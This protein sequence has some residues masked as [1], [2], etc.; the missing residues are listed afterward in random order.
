[1][2][3]P[4]NLGLNPSAQQNMAHL[5]EE[6]EN[7]RLSCYSRLGRLDE[8]ALQASQQTIGVPRWPSGR[9]HFRVVHRPGG[10]VMLI[11]DG[12]S[13]PFDDLQPEAN[14]NGL[15]L[16]FFLETPALEIASS[17]SEIKAS[18]QFQLL[19]TVCSLAAGHGGIRHII[20]DMSLLSTEAEG[21][22]QVIPADVAA[23][24]A[25]KDGRVGALLG[26]TDANPSSEAYVPEVI[27]GMPLSEVRLVN[28]KLLTLPE[29]GL[30]TELGSEGRRKLSELFVGRDRLA[31]SLK[32]SSMI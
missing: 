4:L 11:S 26:L 29:L 24:I 13:D 5:L 28:I 16:E 2:L 12:L 1:V 23:A 19:Y 14:Q 31:S 17:P 3:L 7:A 25:N 8:M 32:R 22:A 9:Q 30:I 10:K 21:V 27:S 18:W 6:S 15:G 20:D